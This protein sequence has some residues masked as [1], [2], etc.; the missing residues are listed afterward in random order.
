M[1][2]ILRP[3]FFGWALTLEGC[4]APGSRFSQE[5]EAAG[6]TESDLPTQRAPHP[7]LTT[8]LAHLFQGGP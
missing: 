4:R 2:T 3:T 7:A 8:S 1:A 6:K 5:G